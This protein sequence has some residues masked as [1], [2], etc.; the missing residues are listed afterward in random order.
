MAIAGQ[1]DRPT[2]FPNYSTIPVQANLWPR[3]AG[4]RVFSPPSQAPVITT[5]E[6]VANTL[7]GAGLSAFLNLTTYQS[8]ETPEITLI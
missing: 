6:H 4:S 1:Q 2:G 8:E 5:W 3:Q 7:H